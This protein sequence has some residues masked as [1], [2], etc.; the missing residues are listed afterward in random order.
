MSLDNPLLAPVQKDSVARLVLNR[1]EEALV[2]KELKPGDLLPSENELVKNLGV[3]KSSVREAIKML[4]AMGVVEI[5]RGEGTF[6]RES[7][8]VDSINPLVFALL[9]E[10]GTSRDILQLRAMFEP[11]YTFMAMRNA[12]VGD[13]QA[14][15]ATITGFEAH[16]ARGTHTVDT[17]MAFHLAILNATHNPFVVKIGQ[18][19][20]KLFKGSMQRAVRTIPATAVADHKRIFHA[21]CAKDEEKLQ[22]AITASFQGWWAHLGG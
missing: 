7:P 16:V 2:N 11:A 8:S 12:T 6:I 3:G 14:I 19:I 20:L 9:L 5:R 13:L 22:E 10:Q 17:D 18:V 21:F 15:E 4:E 1:I